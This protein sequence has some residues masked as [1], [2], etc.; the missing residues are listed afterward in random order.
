MR[1]EPG[2]PQENPEPWLAPKY[3]SPRGTKQHITPPR[4]EPPPP[5]PRAAR[6]P[7]PII[8]P[9]TGRALPNFPTLS[10]SGPHGT[11]SFQDRAARCSHQ[12]GV[13]GDAAG[14]RNA[15]IGSCINQ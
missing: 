6:V 13:Y 11:E 15:Y 5:P 7:P 12:A 9:E 8:A 1:P 10:P 2:Q 4:R 14:N 3:R